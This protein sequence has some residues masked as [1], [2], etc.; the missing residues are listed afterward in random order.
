M[1]KFRIKLGD[2]SGKVVEFFKDALNRNELLLTIDSNK[3][4]ILEVENVSGLKEHIKGSVQALGSSVSTNE[5]IFFTRFLKT[6]LL[7]GLNLSEAIQLM[8]EQTKNP[9]FCRILMQINNKIRVGENFSDAL[10]NF[11]SVFGPGFVKSIRAGEMTGN[12]ILVLEEYSKSLEKIANLRKKLTAAMIYPSFLIALTVT[13]TIYIITNVIPQFQE[14]FESMGAKVPWSTELLLNFSAFL[15]TN[16]FLLLFT[17]LGF[18]FFI[19]YYI[20]SEDGAL[21]LDRF[22]LKLPFFQD[23]SREY[24]V[25]LFSRMTAACLASGINLVECLKI[26]ADTIQN[27]VFRTAIIEANRQIESGVS[28]YKA[29]SICKNFPHLWLQLVK[30][31]EESGALNS[32][33]N[34]AA[35]FF[36]NEADNRIVLLVSIVEPAL[37]IIVLGFI[38]ALV[39]TMFIPILTAAGNIK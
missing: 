4:F 37:L 7:S 38:A 35:E 3:F 5:L 23:L 25:S 14:L 15:E 29:L 9:Y 21:Q 31:G 39:I 28:F 12:L 22:I 8:T 32:L 1:P 11:E 26:S 17:F 18:F 16:F 30:I 33:L 10:A 6:M 27:Q 2:E 36:E 19:Y 34:E 13:A 24:N 20:T